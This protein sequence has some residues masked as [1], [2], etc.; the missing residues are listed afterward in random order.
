MCGLFGACLTL[1]FS[2]TQCNWSALMWASYN[3]QENVVKE[4]LDRRADPDI[5][6]EVRGI[7]LTVLQTAIFR[8]VHIERTCRQQNKCD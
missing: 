1:F 4:L 8:L 3:G 6:A 7:V 5:K 2:P